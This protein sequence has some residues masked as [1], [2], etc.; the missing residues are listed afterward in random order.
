VKH[1]TLSRFQD[2]VSSVE[3]QSHEL[4][5][6]LEIYKCKI[7]LT[8]GSNLRILEKYDH[9]RLVYYS[10]YWLTAFGKLIIGWDCAPHHQAIDS[11]PH[12]QHVGSRQGILSSD[13]RNLSNVLTVIKNSLRLNFKEHVSP[14]S[15]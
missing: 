14:E 10:Y 5:K 3:S 4:I 1:N 9:E 8:D 11:F 12:H 2:I 7:N 15:P 6:R 13:I